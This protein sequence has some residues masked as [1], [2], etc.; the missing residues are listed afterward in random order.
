[1]NIP[2]DKLSKR[3]IDGSEF[4]RHADNA[5]T[6]ESILKSVFNQYLK[7]L[8][9]GELKRI[10]MAINSKNIYVVYIQDNL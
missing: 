9:S 3:L 5:G 2:H 8:F 6:K 1:M 7:F 10:I 4:F